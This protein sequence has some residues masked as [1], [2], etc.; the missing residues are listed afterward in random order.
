MSGHKPQEVVC[1]LMGCTLVS[2]SLA[3]WPLVVFEDEK[4]EKDCFLRGEMPTR[5]YRNLKVK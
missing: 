2:G 1:E 4:P 5:R 3:E